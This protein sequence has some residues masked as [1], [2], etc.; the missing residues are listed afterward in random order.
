MLLITLLL[1]VF[2]VSACGSSSD[3]DDKELKK[4]TLA[5]EW[6]PNGLH[7][8]ILFGQ[9]KGFFKDEGLEVEMVVPTDMESSQKLVALGKAEFGIMVGQY[10]ISAVGNNLSGDM[11]LIGIADFQPDLPMG[12]QVL[13]ENMRTVESFRGKKFGIINS[14]FERMV[15]RYVLASGGLTEKDIDLIDPGFNLVA[16]LISGQLDGAT[17]TTIFEQNEA[18]RE[19]GKKTNIFFYKNYGFGGYNFCIGTNANWLKENEDTA[20]AFLR[21]FLKSFKMSLEADDKEIMKYWMEAHPEFDAAGEMEIWL[22][23]KPSLVSLL[24]KEKG[25]GFIDSENMKNWIQVMYDNK[26]LERQL[27]VSEIF[28]NSYLPEI[29]LIPSTIDELIARQESIFQN[30]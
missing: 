25:L 5:L 8:P 24:Q 27:N 29:P 23:L 17:A 18:E 15:F 19:S 22:D 1:F 14:D 10:I 2:M 11:P 6:G 3:K 12:V 13:D 7:A 20:R 16:P 9:A 28:T 21:A 30:R 26:I 4:V